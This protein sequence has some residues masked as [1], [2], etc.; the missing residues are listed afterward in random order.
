MFLLDLDDFVDWLCMHELDR[1][2]CAGFSFC[3]SPL[4]TYLLDK[5][6]RLVSLDGITYGFA[7]SDVSWPLPGWA[8]RYHRL[9]DR[10]S[11]EWILTGGQAFDLLVSLFS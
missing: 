10:F 2:G 5:T 7:S 9:L 8:C 1:V 4:S 6:G 11:S 3:M